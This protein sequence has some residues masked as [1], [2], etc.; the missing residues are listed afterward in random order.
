VNVTKISPLTGK[1]TTLDLP[2]TK[3]QLEELA[4]PSRRLIQDIFPQLTPSQREFLQTGYTDED[5]DKLFP[6]EDEW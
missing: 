3:E 5:W 2:V 1:F 4:S 6:P